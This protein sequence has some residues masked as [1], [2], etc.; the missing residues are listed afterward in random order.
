[1]PTTPSNSAGP[2]CPRCDTLIVWSGNPA[3]PFCSLRCKLID[4]G[5]WLDEEYRVPADDDPTDRD[6]PPDAS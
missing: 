5:R 6:M 1:M 4:L 3:R 2:R